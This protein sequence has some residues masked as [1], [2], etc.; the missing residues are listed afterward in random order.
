A[1]R[2]AAGV[3]QEP[4]QHAGV[5]PAL[6]AAV[7]AVP[8]PVHARHGRAP[9]RRVAHAGHR[10]QPAAPAPQGAHDVHVLQ[11]ERMGAASP[12]RRAGGPCA[13]HAR[14]GGARVWRAHRRD[15]ADRRRARDGGGRERAVQQNGAAAAQAGRAD[16][17]R[18]RHAHCVAP[19]VARH[20]RVH[21][22]G[23][24]RELLQRQP[25]QRVPA[26]RGVHHVHAAQVGPGHDP[27]DAPR[28][29]DAR[30]A[31]PGAGAVRRQHH[32]RGGLGGH[33]RREHLWRAPGAPAGRGRRGGRRRARRRAAAVVVVRAARA[34]ARGADPGAHAAQLWAAGQ[35]DQR[36]DVHRVVVHARRGGVDAEPR[37]AARV[38]RGARQRQRG[39]RVG[40]RHA[41]R[42]GA[43]GAALPAH[44]GRPGVWRRARQ[45]VARPV[46]DAGDGVDVCLQPGGAAARVCAAGAADRE[47]RGRRRPAVPDAG[48][49]AR[50][51]GVARRDGRGAADLGAAVPGQHGGQSAAG[52]V[53]PGVAVL[54]GRRRDAGRPPAAVPRR[55]AARRQGHPHAGRLRRLYARERRRL[56]ALFDGRARRRRE[57]RRPGRRGRWRQ[58]PLVV[59]RGAVAA[60][61]ARHGGHEHQRRRLRGP[62][63]RHW[64]RGR[65]PPLAARRRGQP[66][67]PGRSDHAVPDPD[68][69]H[70]QRAQGADPRA[71]AGGRGGQHRGEA[72]H[73]ARRVRAAAR[74][75]PPG[76]RGARGAARLCAVSVDPRGD[77][78][79]DALGAGGHHPVAHPGVGHCVGGPGDEPACDRVADPDACVVGAERA[80]RAAG[81]PAARHAD[82]P[83]ADAPA[84]RPRH[85]AAGRA[86]R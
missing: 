73:R 6:H 70:R 62:A 85:G 13:R 80:E 65:L 24:D 74:A 28:H 51:A 58:L 34:A 57:G 36:S 40:A 44:H 66:G 11:G 55:P 63:A 76:R 39:A 12:R 82:A 83:G 4:A 59:R 64:R 41:G 32:R 26:R 14:R 20:C 19:A 71:L 37:G 53:V 17:R 43:R 78:A 9:R 35:G 25:G 48:H 86:A 7:A 45:R 56:P 54:G 5:D 81:A 10:P 52:L 69:A 79:Q 3:H 49:A 72:G 27:G 77:D 38:P 67:P 68:P 75:D 21:A 16:V 29:R 2:G 18:E 30:G 46:D 42:R 50:R 8:G 31:Q 22:A 47:R 84:V 1:D 33:G 23:A 15:R 61:A 60:A